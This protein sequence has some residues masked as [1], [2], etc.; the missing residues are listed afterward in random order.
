MSQ[1]SKAQA[2]NSIPAFQHGSGEGIPSTSNQE[3]FHAAAVK[4]WLPLQALPWA[5]NFLAMAL[6]KQTTVSSPAKTTC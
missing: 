2:A 1:L 3:T 4:G 5:P 6:M